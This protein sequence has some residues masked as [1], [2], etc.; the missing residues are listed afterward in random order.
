MSRTL[1]LAPLV[2]LLLWCGGGVV[3]ARQPATPP[4]VVP[5][6]DTASVELGTARPGPLAPLED[7]ETLINEANHSFTFG[8]GF[9]YWENDCVNTVENH[10]VYIRRRSENGGVT[11]TLHEVLIPT[12]D[13]CL[14]VGPHNVADDSGFFY[15]NHDQERLEAR[16][17]GEPDTAIPIADLVA[18]S[19]H[20]AVDEDYVYYSQPLGIY[21]TNKDFYG[22]VRISDAAKLTGLAVDDTS[23]YW[24]DDTGLWRSDKTCTSSSCWNNKEQL[25]TVGGEHLSWKDEGELLW[26]N[27]SGGYWRIYGRKL[28]VAG[29]FSIYSVPD[30]TTFGMGRPVH[31][32]GCYFWL[33]D[34]LYN[35]IN[36]PN[37]LLRRMC[38]PQAGAETI[39]DGLLA[40]DPLAV[41]TLGVVFGDGSG[42]YRMPFD[43]EAITKDFSVDAIEVTQAIQSL[44][45]DVRLV[46]RKTTY[47]RVFGSVTANRPANAVQVELRGFRGGSELTGSP[48][49]PPLNGPQALAQGD[50]WNRGET[51]GNWLF[52]LPGSWTEEGILHLKAEID[53]KGVYDDPTPGSSN[54]RSEYVEFKDVD[55]LCI[56]FVPVRT[57]QGQGSTNNPHFGAL[58]DR[59]K[60]MLPVPR[61]QWVVDQEPVEELETCY[62]WGFIPYPCWGPLELNEEGGWTEFGRDD[63]SSVLDALVMRSVGWDFEACPSGKSHWVGMVT[64]DSPTMDGTEGLGRYDSSASWIKFPS[65]YETAPSQDRWAWP[66]PGNT[67]VHELGHNHNRYHVHCGGE[68]NI[69][70]GYPYYNADGKSCELDDGNLTAR[71]THFGFDVS[72]L[73]PI[74]PTRAADVMSYGSRRWISDYTWDELYVPS[75]GVQSAAAGERP[76]LA[77]TDQMD[78]TSSNSLVL[79]TG[80]LAPSANTGAL[81]Y[82]WVYPTDALSQRTLEG[83]KTLTAPRVDEVAA[84]ALAPQYHLRLVDGNGVTID[85]RALEPELF[86]DGGSDVEQSGF[87]QSFPAPAVPVARI[88]LM[89]DTTVVDSL[90]PGESTP[91]VEILQPASGETFDDQLTVVWR[92]TDGDVDDR[93]LYNVHYSPDLGQS[94]R[95]LV[96]NWPGQPAAD[97]VTL[98][99]DSL[100]GVPGSTTGG[101]VRVAASDG[102]NTG[103]ATSSSFVVSNQPPQIYIASPAVDQV[104]EA[105]DAIVLR[106]GASDVEDGSLSGAALSWEVNGE[107][108]GTGSEAILAG[109]APGTYTVSLT[110]QDSEGEESTAEA[111]LNVTPLYVPDLPWSVDDPVM[112]GLCDDDAYASGP[113]LPL[114]PYSGGGQGA[115]H[116]VRTDDY[117]YA[118]FSG[119]NRGVAPTAPIMNSA[120]LL[121]DANYSR[122]HQFQ[123]GDYWFYVQE[124]GTPAT[125]VGNA[126]GY[127][128]PDGLLTRISANENAWNAELR[129]DAGAIGGWDRVVG[130]EL[131]HVWVPETGARH[132]SWPYD[133]ATQW[134]DSWATTVLGDW[135]RIDSL[136][137]NEAMEDGPGTI[138]GIEGENFVS[139]A[140]ALWNGEPL[141]T[142]F[143]DER[144]LFCTIEPSNLLQDGTAEIRVRNPGLE[145]APSNALTFLIKN[146]APQITSLTPN[147]ATEGSS[148][149]ISVIGDDFD[150]GAVALWNG[151]P[152][153]TSVFGSSLLM[154]SVESSDLAVTRD[155]GVSVVN[156]DPSEGPS[157]VVTFTILAPPNRAPAAPSEPDPVNRSSDVPT[158]KELTWRGSEPDGQPLRYNIAF[159]TSSPP[160]RRASALTS[161]R[162]NPGR[163]ETATKYYWRITASDGLSTTVGPIWSFQTS[164]DEAPNNPPATPYDPNPAD[165]STD[166]PTGQVLSW[167]SQ[168]KDGDR[169][170]YDVYFG[171]RLPLQLKGRGLTSSTYD[172]GTLAEGRTYYWSIHVTDGTD[173]TEGPT[174]R[175]ETAEQ[176]TDVYLPLVLRQSP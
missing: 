57:H 127:E 95:T 9:L 94:W 4:V 79:V 20:L 120:G 22:G 46:T 137:P 77:C 28:R 140:T 15:V 155:V 101:L 110:A 135:P 96:T 29:A 87:T 7:P 38:S 119:L 123:S 85:D 149:V 75:F 23:I 131:V 54:A 61:V 12:H 19:P 150:D 116:V 97:T 53:P 10:P 63:E 26:I 160:R 136:S 159:G 52:K 98:T 58:L 66:R 111:G 134:P 48:L 126:W 175:F 34:T 173:T 93:L 102:Y 170:T 147:E 164:R 114:K 36:P 113:L 157:N 162:Y 44:E 3:G 86:F 141:A 99:L 62:G 84:R 122:E 103:M 128:G 80:M 73:A 133:A 118:C 106:G 1:R 174:W 163:L 158:N 16:L 45:N 2:V 55:P 153:T 6:I 156:P 31:H 81:S 165:R 145:E 100:L 5:A 30:T 109:M 68:D 144:R 14:S 104:F 11:Q 115:V 142:T 70:D 88:D 112:D 59:A 35:V 41:G 76:K 49:R 148:G 132:H 18:L 171:T 42:I 60:A 91:S 143:L 25:A 89:I 47:V 154:F 67:L 138:I 168:D 139:G 65:P 43:A 13:Q 161:P 176:L 151:E 105:G 167:R 146:P 32:D 166:V 37:N 125:K 117:L 129:I 169:L 71:S 121:I 152:K 21:R 24:L 83:W 74:K 27:H 124:D 39:A 107:S 69:D 130:L 90:E 56:A 78:L 33:E 50:G 72:L 172:A 17:T 64:H 40:Q 108:A 8:G 82:A 51:E 92:A